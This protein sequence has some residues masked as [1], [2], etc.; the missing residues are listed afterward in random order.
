MKKD[1]IMTKVIDTQTKYINKLVKLTES[2]ILNACELI[3]KSSGKLVISG[4]GKTQS[5]ALKLCSTLNS[6]GFIRDL[7]DNLNNNYLIMDHY[8]LNIFLIFYYSHF[9]F[10]FF[11]FFLQYYFFF[12]FNL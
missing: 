9:D 12:L 1:T 10:I 11:F 6:I 4:V 3:Y 2:D 8:I 5:I 7:F